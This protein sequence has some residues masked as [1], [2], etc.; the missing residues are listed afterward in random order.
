MTFTR[1]KL[2]PQCQAENRDSA[3]FCSVCRTALGSVVPVTRGPAQQPGATVVGL[4][5]ASA[6][7]PPV[8][9][10]PL[11]AELPAVP[12]APSRHK[13][14]AGWR[15][16]RVGWS[17]WHGRVAVEGRV[18]AVDPARDLPL[19]FDPGRLLVLASV[20]LV[21]LG[22]LVVTATVALVL[23]I[24]LLVLG[25]GGLCVMPVLLPVIGAALY[26]IY[27]ALRGRRMAPMVEMR[28]EDAWTGQPA[29][30][31]LFLGQGSSNVRLGDRV[32]VYG[33]R[34]LFNST[35]RA[36][37]V[38]VTETNGLPAHYGV[39]GLRPWP[40]WIGLLTFA[41]VLAGYWWLF[42]NGM[43]AF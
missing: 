24:V 23:A 18:S 19:P 4:P 13:F 22:L 9:P 41:L 33:S 17:F 12:P 34:M 30:V 11:S 31:I 15:G 37:H 40:V 6:F 43:L 42:T 10:V 39:D 1:I 20:G 16:A 21:G 38:D 28:V 8:Q 35:I 26:P 32:R 5:P 36:T 2:C 3:N 14:W 29:S 7:H 25:I 27:N